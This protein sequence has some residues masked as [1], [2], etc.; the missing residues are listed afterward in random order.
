[1]RHPRLHS[2]LSLCNTGPRP[3]PRW[4]EQGSDGPDPDH[5]R[6]DSDGRL[7]AGD[8][9]GRRPVV[10]VR[11]EDRGQDRD[12]EHAA[13]LA[14][15]V[16]GTGRLALLVRADRRQDDVGDR[17]EEQAHPDP[18]EDER[19]DHRLVGDRRGHDRGKPGERHSLER[20]ARREDRSPADA[21]GEDPGDRGDDDRHPRPGQ[22]PKTGLER[23]VALDD[24]EELAEQED[25]P[26]HPEV[27]QQRDGVGG[28]ERPAPEERHRQHRVGM[29]RL[30]D[31]ERRPAG[32][33]RRRCEPTT[34][35]LPQPRSLPLMTP[36]T[37]ASRPALIRPRPGTSRRPS[38]P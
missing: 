34:C 31:D 8:V 14:D 26:E 19:H 36:H 21:V 13:D 18:G 23:A 17:G 29:T 3:G 33:R 12:P 7:E 11:A 10:A 28:A 22:R 15:R 2:R 16:R 1:M 4:D 37:S 32:R 30:P 38:G 6:P 5:D 9:R 24:L 35:G 20:H 25:R 27:H